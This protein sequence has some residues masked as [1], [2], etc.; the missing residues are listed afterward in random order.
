MVVTCWHKLD[1][2]CTM[3]TTVSVPNE[4]CPPTGTH[5]RAYITFSGS[6]MKRLDDKT[7]EITMMSHSNLETSI[8]VSIINSTAVGIPIS[9]VTHFRK[10]LKIKENSIKARIQHK[11]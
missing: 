2:G 5:V 3:L 7:T 9:F 10:F 6:L 1:D 8:P 4:W 11:E